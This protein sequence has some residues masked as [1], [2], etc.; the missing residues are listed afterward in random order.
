MEIYVQETASLLYL[1]RIPSSSRELVMTFAH[2]FPSVF[3]KV[4]YFL[5]MGIAPTAWYIL[6]LKED[7]G[8]SGT[9][10]VEVG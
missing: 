7:L 2:L 5:R 6:L 3:A 10:G 1:K 4:Q 9:N 8:C